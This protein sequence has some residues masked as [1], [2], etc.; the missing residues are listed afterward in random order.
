MRK[1]EEVKHLHE[2][3]ILGMSKASGSREN[4]Y[5]QIQYRRNPSVLQEMEMYELRQRIE[6]QSTRKA[7]QPS[8]YFYTGLLAEQ[9]PR[10]IEN[11]FAQIL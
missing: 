4:L 1:A 8:L 10:N 7:S 2:N 11:V 6:C 3:F 9:F 5:S